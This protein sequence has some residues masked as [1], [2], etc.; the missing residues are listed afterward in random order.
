MSFYR[1]LWLGA[2]GAV[3][4]LGAMPTPANA[5]VSVFAQY[6]SGGWS[7][8]VAPS[9]IYEYTCIPNATL[10]CGGTSTGTEVDSFPIGGTTTISNGSLPTIPLGSV[11]AQA[12]V[13]WSS[14]WPKDLTTSST[15]TGDVWE[16][17]L[18]DNNFNPVTSIT[19]N[20]SPSMKA[21][22][23]VILPE[24]LTPNPLSNQSFT[25]AVT[26]FGGNNVN[27]YYEKETVSANTS[28]LGCSVPSGL[29]NQQNFSGGNPDFCGFFGFNGGS[30]SSL[31]ISI[32]D[33]KGT[34]CTEAQLTDRISNQVGC[35]D[36]GIGVGDFV[37]ILSP[38]VPE[39][40]S[41]ALL[42]A[43]LVGLGLIRRRL[44]T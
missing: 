24:G 19:L 4:A 18:L 33:N 27:T 26:G 9:T 15:Y 35:D 1:S 13:P 5:S 16:S 30:T 25:I 40:S 37:D 41:L 2:L 29:P 10:G 6:G 3:A 38:S 14:F 23:F 22:G 34:F 31:T 42:G 36:P 43:G 44:R 12:T 20:L 17:H 7:S 11:Q 39:P 32:T 8:N 21:L 28:T